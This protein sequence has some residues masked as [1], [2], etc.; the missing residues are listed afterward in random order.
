TG[1]D[2]AALDRAGH[3]DGGG[4][5]C[6]VGGPTL[7]DRDTARL[8]DDRRVDE[9][10][11]LGRAGL[12]QAAQ[13]RSRQRRGL[14]SR[15]VARQ[16]D[17]ERADASAASSTMPPRATLRT[18]APGFICAIALSPMSP[19]V[20]RVSGTW[21]VTASD[22]SS[23]ASNVTSSTPR[24]AACSGVTYGSLPRR[25]IPSPRAR[26]AMAMPILPRPTIPNVRPRSWTPWSG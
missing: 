8:R 25:V 13:C 24:S 18:N 23:S 4:E 22:R 26:S 21:T 2:V 7:D 5:A 1:R 14:G 11:P 10:H 12:E 3:G 20:A 16:L 17:G 6:R 9:V 15:Q 19:V